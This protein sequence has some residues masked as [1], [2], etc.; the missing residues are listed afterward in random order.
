MDEAAQELLDVYHE[1]M[2]DELN[3]GEG[4]NREMYISV[5]LWA[6]ELVILDR[7]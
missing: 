2:A 7:L 4:K 3:Y 1:H 5:P 6:L